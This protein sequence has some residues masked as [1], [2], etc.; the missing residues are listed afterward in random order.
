MHFFNY[1]GPSF[2]SILGPCS[3][4]SCLVIHISSLSAICRVSAAERD[5]AHGISPLTYNVCK[6]CA[7]KEHHMFPPWRILDSNLEFLRARVS[8]VVI[9]KRVETHVQPLRVPA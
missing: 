1:L 9:A 7:A 6:H 8:V 2:S 4:H 5:C 3:C